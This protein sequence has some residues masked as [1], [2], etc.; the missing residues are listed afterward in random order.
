ML[1]LALLALFCIAMV[2]CQKEVREVRAP[3]PPHL[4]MAQR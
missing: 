2:G 4:A 3:Q 1:R